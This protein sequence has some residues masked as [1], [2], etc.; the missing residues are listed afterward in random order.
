MIAP[1][2]VSLGDAI[3]RTYFTTGQNFT[4]TLNVFGGAGFGTPTNCFVIQGGNVNIRTFTFASGNTATPVMLM[5]GAGRVSL[6]NC[7]VPFSG[8]GTASRI[9]K[10]F[11]GT[12]SETGTLRLGGKYGY[13]TFTTLK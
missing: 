5:G 6:V 3:S 10:K 13:E 7:V 12:V 9:M 1:G 8:D 11:S 2:D 4:G